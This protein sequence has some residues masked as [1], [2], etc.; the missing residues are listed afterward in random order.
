[1]CK[2]IRF[3][4][5]PESER[6]TDIVRKTWSERYSPEGSV[7]LGLSIVSL[8]EKKDMSIEDV[9]KFFELILEERVLKSQ[10]RAILRFASFHT[11]EASRVWK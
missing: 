8:V 2:I 9:C 11:P 5:P 4:I 1:M 10:I 6:F 7:S 3:P